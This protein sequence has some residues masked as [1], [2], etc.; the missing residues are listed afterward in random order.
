MVTSIPD[1]NDLFFF[2]Q[3]VD[4]GGFAPAA[5]ALGVPKSK[6][7]RR[8]ALLEQRLG[9]R[10]IQRSTR[11]F[12]VTE[13]GQEYYRRCVAMLV[14]AEA[15]QELIDRTRSEPHGTVHVSCPIT[16][17][18]ARVS[19]MLVKFMGECPYVKVQLEATNRR[20]DVIGEGFDIAL[21]VRFPPIEDSDLV[22]RNLGDSPQ[23]LV[24][25]PGLLKRM[26]GIS[27]PADLTGL[28]TLDLGP[29]SR[30]HAWHLTN[31]DG[32]SATVVHEPRLV[33]D[34]MTALRAAALAGIGI[35]EL[36]DMLVAGDIA[37]GR[38]QRLLPTW[39][40]AVGAI[41]AIFPSR[42]GLIPA[43]RHLLD[44]LAVEFGRS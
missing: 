41:L 10:L 37:A 28:P 33:T 18:H 31:P 6:L 5:R 15:A 22:M 20:V 30:K 14:E 44:F 36:P 42:R 21:R 3:V 34:D 24:G 4:N 7:S 1:L 9:V 38:L 23:L 12:S 13:I 40:S 39:S 17:L 26:P 25:S 19:H 35:V 27:V 2:A 29:P 11:R 16:L 32:V 43:V 8:I